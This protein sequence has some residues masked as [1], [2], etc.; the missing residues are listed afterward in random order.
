MN[1]SHLAFRSGAE[2]VRLAEDTVFVTVWH[3]LNESGTRSEGW[4]LALDKGTGNELWRVVLP[5]ESS[6]L[7]VNSPAVWRNLV[8]VTVANGQTYAIDRNSHQI[9]WQIPQHLPSGTLGTALITGAEVYGDF[10]YASGSDM[11]VRAYHAQDGMEIWATFAG[12]NS[13]GILITEKFVYAQDGASIYMIDRATGGWYAAL[14][15]PRRTYDYAYTT[16]P[17]FANGNVFAT[18]SDGEWSFKEP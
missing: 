14:G 1:R 5:K 3:F 12:Q 9:A 8:I 15:H 18:F 10:V 4:L 7:M 16:A 13:G 11:L 6:G 17:A 2:G